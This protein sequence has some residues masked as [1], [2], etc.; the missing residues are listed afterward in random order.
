MTARTLTIGLTSVIALT[1]C[2][3]YQDAIPGT[4]VLPNVSSQTGSM[5]SSVSSSAAQT[6]SA[7]AASDVPGASSAPAAIPPEGTNTTGLPLTLPP[8]F[9]IETFAKDLPGARVIVKDGMGNYWVSQPEQGTVTMLELRGE[10]VMR[11]NAVFRNLNKPHGLA[12]DPER[13]MTLYIAEEHRVVRAYLYSDGPMET[14]AELP[15]GGRHTT[16]TLQFGRD[17]RLYVSIG[18]TCDTCVEVNEEH[19]SI[20]SMNTD[21]SDRKIFAMGLRNAVFF[22]RHPSTQAFWATEMGR[23]FQGDDIPPEEV[24][25]LKDDAHYGWP[26]CYGDRVRD[27]TF[28][29]YEDFDC[30]ATEPPH[31]TLP[32]HIAPLGLAFIPSSWPAEYRDDLLVAEHGSWNS[33]NKVGYKVVRI[34]LG[35]DGTVAGPAVD[36]LGGFLQSGDRVVGRPVDVFFDGADLLITDDKSG[37]VYRVRPPAS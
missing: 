24:N 10:A 4:T 25:I 26:Y 35:A 13:G 16:R 20:I 21:G 2:V 32:A 37:S 1:G 19:G 5:Q 3:G 15:R 23:D 22:T 14:V 30:S 27:R 34:P 33:S 31:A 12:V 11:Q 7:A 18:S 29:L 8:G 28:Q 17:G 9:S 6:S 36:F